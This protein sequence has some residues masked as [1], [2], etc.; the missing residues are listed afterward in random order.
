MTQLTEDNQIMTFYRFNVI[1]CVNQFTEWTVCTLESFK[2]P[3]CEETELMICRIRAG[4]EPVL[5][6]INTTAGEED[7]K[8]N[9][10]RPVLCSIV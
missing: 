9:N 6:K 1:N 7:T 10:V 3:G 2:L 8:E 4:C 5:V